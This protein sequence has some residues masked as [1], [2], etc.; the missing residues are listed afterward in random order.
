MHRLTTYPVS[1]LAVVLCAL[2]LPSVAH[3]V[4]RIEFVS[5]SE[6]SVTGLRP[7]TIGQRTC[8]EGQWTFRL[9]I[10]RETSST[11]ALWLSNNDGCT[12]TSG[13]S[14]CVPL[15]TTVV[16]DTATCS[17]GTCWTFTV[18]SPFLVSPNTGAC[19]ADA[20]GYTR[21]FAWVDD[22]RIVSPRVAWDTLAPAA[23]TSVT[24]ARDGESAVNLSWNYVVPLVTTDAA[25]DVMDAS[26][27]VADVHADG[28]VLDAISTDASD[29]VVDVHMDGEVLDADTTDVVTSDV[30]PPDVA[31]VDV[32]TDVTRTR[33]REYE[34]VRRFWVLCESVTSDAACGNFGSLDVTN[35]SVLAEY[36]AQCGL[37]ADTV[38]TNN[39]VS[40]T[41]LRMGQVYRYGVVAED[42]AGNRSVVAVASTCV[43]PG[44]Y[45]DFWE[46][47]RSSGGTAQPG[48]HTTPGNDR[49]RDWVVWLGITVIAVLIRK[50]R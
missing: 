44:A 6:G 24:A 22:E 43:G 3:A 37:A 28:V 7:V 27:A 41:G 23:P 31:P 32:A 38:L 8:S 39:R 11:P 30:E 36:S 16:R 33:T 2:G 15:S 45:T 17:M 29:A 34:T 49:S 5:R 46:S 20:T 40:L 9:V 25:V 18:A 12:R 4:P 35:D 14:A 1:S 13:D 42:L 19:T 47:Y 48:C 50:K 21:V 10:D 26:D